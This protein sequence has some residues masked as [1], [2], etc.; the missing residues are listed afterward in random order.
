MVQHAAAIDV[1]ER[2]VARGLQQAAGVECDAVSPRAAARFSA[3]P[4]AATDRS[5]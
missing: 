1:V 5:R 4:R 2:A 3:M